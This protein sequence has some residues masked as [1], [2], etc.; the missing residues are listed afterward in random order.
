M[1]AQQQTGFPIVLYCG[2]RGCNYA[3]ELYRQLEVYGFWDL[4]IFIDGW[5]GMQR[6]GLPTQTGGDSWKGFPSL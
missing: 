5:E 2:S 4:T 3:E 1:D 6:A